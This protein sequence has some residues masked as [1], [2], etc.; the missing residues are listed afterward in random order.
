MRRAVAIKLS[1]PEVDVLE[2][3]KRG[4]RVSVRLA[5][6]AVIVLHAAEG[7]ENQQIAAIMG[8]SR[9]KAGRWRDRYAYPLLSQASTASL[10]PPSLG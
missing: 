6:R 1:G 8:I 5:E 3:L 9:Q 10:P 4:R 7:L 2:K